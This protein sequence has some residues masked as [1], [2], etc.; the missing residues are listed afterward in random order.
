MSASCHL[1]QVLRTAASHVV[2]ANG[3]AVGFEVHARE[4]LTRRDTVPNQCHR[5]GWKRH[6]IVSLETRTALPICWVIVTW[7]WLC[8]GRVI[9]EGERQQRGRALH[10]TD[11]RQQLTKNW[12]RL[13]ASEQ[14]LTRSA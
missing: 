8:R 14:R 5:W 11:Q 10:A 13:L 12:K 3:T 7:C 6:T 4:V 9:G 2:S 1:P